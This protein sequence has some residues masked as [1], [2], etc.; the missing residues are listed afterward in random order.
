MWDNEKGTSGI[1]PSRAFFIR[2]NQSLRFSASIPAGM[3]DGLV[4]A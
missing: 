2:A 3:S 1:A 4:D